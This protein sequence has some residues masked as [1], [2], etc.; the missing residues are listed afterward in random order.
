MFHAR[1]RRSRPIEVGFL[2]N[3]RR[4]D[5]ERKE[6]GHIPLLRGPPIYLCPK[7]RNADSGANTADVPYILPEFAY[8]FETAFG[9][10]DPDFPSCS[11]D[12]PAAA[13]ADGRMYIVNHFLDF[14]VAPGVKIPDRLRAPTTNSNADIEKHTRTCRD[15]HA[16]RSPDFVLLDFVDQG[17]WNR[18]GQPKGDLVS[19]AAC[20]LLGKI[21]ID[22]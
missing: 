12:R 18:G 5:R 9:V 7:S 2:A 17:D 19:D 4:N 10:T 16:G 21:G 1:T 11:I 6:T 20:G 8:F 22:C 3:P 14:E 13:S 15:L